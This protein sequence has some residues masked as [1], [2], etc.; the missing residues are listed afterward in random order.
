MITLYQPQ[1]LRRFD[2]KT[3]DIGPI[4]RVASFLQNTSPT[5]TPGK[6]ELKRVLT[7]NLGLDRSA[8]DAIEFPDS[9]WDLR[10]FTE[11]LH[12]INTNVCV[13][14]GLFV[15]LNWE[16][17]PKVVIA[18]IDG[19]SATQSTYLDRPVLRADM[20]ALFYTDCFVAGTEG[21]LAFVDRNLCNGTA[22]GIFE[23]V[24]AKPSKFRNHKDDPTARCF[25]E[26]GRILTDC[27]LA[28]DLKGY[29]Q[30]F[31][32]ESTLDQKEQ[33]ARD[34]IF[35]RRAGGL[36]CECMAPLDQEIYNTS[37]LLT[38]GS[39]LRERL[40]ST[41]RESIEGGMNKSVLCPAIGEYGEHLGGT[42]T[43]MERSIEA[44]NDTAAYLRFIDL[45]ITNLLHPADITKPIQKI[46]ASELMETLTKR[47][48]WS[49]LS[50]LTGIELPIDAMLH[51]EKAP[52]ESKGAN[53][54][55][56]CKRLYAMDFHTERERRAILGTDEGLAPPN[57]LPDK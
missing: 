53:A 39:V 51:F 17:A 4:N 1:D 32:A 12:L 29:L 34:N 10:S 13:P 9:N 30:I 11:Y 57:Q 24:T 23:A 27:G 22:L 14:H 5:K 15:R 54:L 20:R 38:E 47:F 35:M 31:G 36:I 48:L 16:G 2:L 41:D 18:A 7:D 46:P 49:G 6:A 28:E 37:L 8:V 42:I 33:G 43:A 56:L 40:L 19:E 26:L 55:R 3:S 25:I 45:L 44:G 52:S 50:T 21:N